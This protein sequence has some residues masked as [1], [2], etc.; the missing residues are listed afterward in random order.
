MGSSRLASGSSDCNQT[1]SGTAATI[2]RMNKGQSHGVNMFYFAVCTILFCLHLGHLY[3]NLSVRRSVTECIC[4]LSFI[5]SLRF[6]FPK[7]G[8]L[9]GHS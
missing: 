8:D 4:T 6:I 7:I 1:L 9:Q 5:I 3:P 2:N